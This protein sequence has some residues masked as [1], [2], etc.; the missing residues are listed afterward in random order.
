M[1]VVTEANAMTAKQI[2]AAAIKLP[3]RERERLTEKL[4]ESLETKK[5]REILD[6]WIEEAERRIDEFESGKE[7]AIPAEQVFKRLRA[8]TRR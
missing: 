1:K 4:R 7:V 5:D 2:E 6:A 3:R 8:S